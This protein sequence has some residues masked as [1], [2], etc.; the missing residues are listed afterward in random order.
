VAHTATLEV[1]VRDAERLAL[2][3]QAGTLSM[4]LR[5]TGQAEI[6]PVRSVASA[7]L[8][9]GGAPA[10][11]AA[12]R[13]RRLAAARPPPPSGSSVLVVHG[14]KSDSVAVPRFNVS[15]SAPR[16]GAGA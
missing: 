8:G 13:L 14:D 12:P 3:A 9:S 7:D 1:N 4:A 5:R 10:P 6:A 2:A 11:A 16:F 15:V